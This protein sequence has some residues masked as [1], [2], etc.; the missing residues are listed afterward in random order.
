MSLP[1]FPSVQIKI[2]GYTDNTG[3]EAS[4]LK[5]SGQRAASVKAKLIK[6][7]AENGRIESEGYGQ[8][9]P[10]AS[11]DSEKGRSLNRRIAVSVRKK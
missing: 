8:E 1:A 5:L 6:M 3:N 4:N 7:G 2:G 10:V 9:H 11:N